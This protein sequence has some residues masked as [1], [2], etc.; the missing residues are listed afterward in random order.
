[1]EYRHRLLT[2]G[3]VSEEFRRDCWSRAKHDFA[4]TASSF[5]WTFNSREFPEAPDRLFILRDYQE[6]LAALLIKSIGVHE[7]IIPKSRDMGGTWVPLAVLEWLWQHYEMQ[8][9]LLGSWKQDYVDKAG[10]PSCL[11]WR[12]EYIWRKLPRWFR[13]PVRAK[14]DRKMN[15]LINPVNGSV[16]TG[17][18]TNPN[19]GR[20]S[21]PGII[22]LDE[23]AA[24]DCAYEVLS[25]T[26]AATST[27]WIISTYAGAFGAFYKKVQD[28]L[29]TNPGHVFAMHW[30]KHPDKRRG[31]YRSIKVGDVYELEIIDKEYEW[32]LDERGRNTYRF[33]LDGKTRSPY[34]DNYEKEVAGTK[35]EVAQQL[36]MEPQA[37]GW[38]FMTNIV[39]EQIALRHARPPVD[40]GEFVFDDPMGEIKWQSKADGIVQLWCHLTA[41]DVAYDHAHDVIVGC[42][43]GKGT[44][45]E[46]GS[47]SVASFYD[48]LTKEKIGQIT[49]SQLP[50][51]QFARYVVAAA[52]FF[53]GPNGPALVNFEDNGPGEDFRDEMV[54]VLGFRRLW[55]RRDRRKVDERPT[56]IPGWHSTKDNKKA[57][58]NAY[59]AALNE[60]R[61]WNRCREAIME[62]SEYVTQPDL[63]IAHCDSIQ[64][65][66]L[67]S[68]GESHGD[69]VISDAVAYLALGDSPS[70]AEEEAEPEIPENSFLGRKM[71]FQEQK[72]ATRGSW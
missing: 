44:S 54:K 50:A 36:D 21:R 67:N 19:F 40:R 39:C 53:A 52:N 71:R 46:K 56:D 7:V 26:G 2:A 30:T 32:P 34:Y 68:A 43:I 12:L 49:T 10:D 72:R 16:I 70:I 18:A 69:M 57:L 14:V 35:Q 4:W 61:L 65:Q 20:A 59:R 28:K 8:N 23:F 17:E 45:E 29:K 33:I 22:M 55:M 24:V 47:N 64:T 48:S 63:S 37:A 38:Q 11:F 31:L 25:A 27:R 15:T 51:Y 5:F 42:D 60:D 62:C 41:R 66:D 13:P 1:M 58:L 3:R 9:A 6:E